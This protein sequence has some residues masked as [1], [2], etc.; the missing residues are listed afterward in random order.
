[1]VISFTGT[2]LSHLVLGTYI[3]LNTETTIDLSAYQWVPV[4]S[5]SALIFIASCGALP[6]PYVMVSEILP[7]NVSAL[8]K[9]YTG[10]STDTNQIKIFFLFALS[11]VRR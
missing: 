6:I 2:A 5:F 9:H 3:M 4:A 8:H 1:M 7:E 11:N 10:H